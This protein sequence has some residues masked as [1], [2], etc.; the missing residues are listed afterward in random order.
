MNSKKFIKS[1]AAAIFQSC[2]ETNSIEET[3]FDQGDFIY[4]INIIKYFIGKNL[5]FEFDSLCSFYNSLEKLKEPFLV[6]RVFVI[7]Y[8]TQTISKEGFDL[9]RRRWNLKSNK[10]E[11]LSHLKNFLSF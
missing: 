3:S 9:W 7:L 8:E 1:L 4:K 5:E 6:K 2:L 10:K 11:M